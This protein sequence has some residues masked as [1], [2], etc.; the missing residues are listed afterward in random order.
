MVFSRSCSLS[1]Y[2]YMYL[3]S[4]LG[5]ENRAWGTAKRKV[6]VTFAKVFRSCKKNIFLILGGR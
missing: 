5:A 2:M 4:V 3:K 1:L 6:E